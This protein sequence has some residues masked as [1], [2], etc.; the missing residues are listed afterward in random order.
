MVMLYQFTENQ[1]H[2]QLLLHAVYMPM[3]ALKIGKYPLN[4]IINQHILLGQLSAGEQGH[5]KDGIKALV[6]LGIFVQDGND[7][8]I[9]NLSEGFMEVFDNF[10]VGTVEQVQKE[11]KNA[12]KL[13]AIFN[14]IER[15]VRLNPLTEAPKKQLPSK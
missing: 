1:M 8:C 14:A 9:T 15:D 7:I 4:E 10:S 5:I 2:V 11:L 3:V 12:P 13:Q 6:E